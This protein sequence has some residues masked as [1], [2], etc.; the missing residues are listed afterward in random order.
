SFCYV[1]DLVEGIYRLLL[2]D[3]NDPV[4]LGNPHEMTVLEFAQQV[5]ELTGSPGPIHHKELPVDDPKIRQPDIG[6]ARALLGWE[7]RVP[8][9]TGLEHTIDYFRELFA[10]AP[11]VE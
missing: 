7:P 2:S 9:R 10:T 8:L 6:R 5:L 11:P 4:N 3:T 1:G